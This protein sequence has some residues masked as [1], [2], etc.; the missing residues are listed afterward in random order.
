MENVMQYQQDGRYEMTVTEAEYDE[1]GSLQLSLTVDSQ[2][3]PPLDE[4]L[5]TSYV[6]VS[7]YDNNEFAE[8]GTLTLY[9]SLRC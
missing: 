1:D 9:D 6:K 2:D 5:T 7:V 8:N 3:T 4:L